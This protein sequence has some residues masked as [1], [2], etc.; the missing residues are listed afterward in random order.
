MASGHRR[1]S[2]PIEEILVEQAEQFEFHAFIKILE[3]LNPQSPSLG[4][5]E[6]PLKD[7]VNFK[8]YVGFD[9]PATD[10]R[11]F[12]V[13][14]GDGPPQLTVDFFGIAGH[15]GPLPTPYTQILMDNDRRGDTAFHFFLD[16]FNHRLISI[17]QRIRKKY[18]IALATEM[19][20]NTMMGQCV[21]S[22]LGLALPSLKGRMSIPDR[23]LFPYIG[24]LWGAPRSLVGLQKI[25]SSF[26]RL[27][28]SIEE[29]QGK[30]IPVPLSQRSALGKSG[31]FNVLGKD[32]I[33]GSQFWDQKG[34]ITLHLGPMT[35]PQYMGFLKPGKSYD[36]LCDLVVY[37][38][39]RSA[40]VRINL[41]LDRREIPKTA[42]GKGAAL[43]WT[44]W[45]NR[46]HTTPLKDDDQNTMTA[47][48]YIPNL[49][50]LK[51]TLMGSKKSR[52]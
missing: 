46:G 52:K 21:A 48:P 35:F 36:A 19:P 32:A 29:C 50:P 38:M 30:W 42:L 47:A 45:L 12:L 25:L 43:S 3:E 9:F 17:L 27:P 10:I 34:F 39:G 16:I 14:E 23:S 20:E 41:I 51:K 8:T 40:D 37:Y 11:S 7:I 22:L 2:P 4:V 44:S 33:L 15:P 13:N 24:L 1:K 18:W 31:R 6:D 5:G 26:F 28:V 49:P